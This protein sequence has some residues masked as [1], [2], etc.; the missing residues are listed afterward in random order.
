MTTNYTKG[1]SLERNIVN[2]FRSKGLLAFR[3]AGSHSPVDVVG[4][5]GSFMY[6]IQSKKFKMGSKRRAKELDKI[7]IKEGYY[8]IKPI[9]LAGSWKEIREVLERIV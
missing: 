9:V 6:L 3:S 4:F 5:T 1:A 7:A 2:H 8:Y